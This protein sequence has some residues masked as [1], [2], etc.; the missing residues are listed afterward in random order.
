MVARSR[1]GGA[2]DLTIIQS[3]GTL[4]KIPAWMAEEGSGEAVVVRDPVLLVAALREARAMLDRSLR[5]PG[6]ETSPDSGG[7]NDSDQSSNCICSMPAPIPPDRR[8]RLLTL[9]GTLLSEAAR[10]MADMNNPPATR[11]THDE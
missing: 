11:E 9:T 4:A 8:R 1:R 6:G 2:A 3:D 10:D 7:E 5:L